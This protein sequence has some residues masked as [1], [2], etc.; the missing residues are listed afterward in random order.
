[1]FFA[2]PRR[3]D[4]VL[5]VVAYEAEIDHE[6]YEQDKDVKPRRQEQRSKKLEADQRKNDSAYG[7]TE[8]I[9]PLFHRGHTTFVLSYVRNRQKVHGLTF[10]RGILRV[11]C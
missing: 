4:E 7:K 10:Q 9:P 11:S 5:I 1:M 2:C 8:S 3:N 6:E